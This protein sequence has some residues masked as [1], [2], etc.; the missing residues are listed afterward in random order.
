[1]ATY[2]ITAPD[3]STV[4]LSAK[5]PEQA[6]DIARKSWQSLPRLVARAGG[7]RILQS[8]D[9]A[10]SFTDGTYSTTN[11]ELVA[12]IEAGESPG[13]VAISSQ[14]QATIAQHPVAAI[15]NEYVRG[16]LGVGSRADEAA[17]AMFGPGATQGMRALSGAMERERPGTSAL[18]GIAGAATSVAGLLGALPA[19]ATQA[20]LGQMGTGATRMLPQMARAVLTGTPLAAMEG[21]IY[22]SGEGTTSEERAANAVSGA[23]F[24]AGAGVIGGVAG[25]VVGRG[26]ENMTNYLRNSAPK[27]IAEVL[28]ISAE[29]ARVIKATFEQGGDF[30]A[31]QANLQRAGSEGMLVDAG[32]AAQALADATAASG[33]AASAAVKQ[34]IED[35]ASRVAGAFESQLDATLGP[36]PLGPR[37]KIEE[38]ATRTKPERDAAYGAALS[39]PVDYSTGAPGEAILQ[40]LARIAPEDKAAA[41]KSAN[42]AMLADGIPS[43]ALIKTDGTTEPLYNAT[44]LHYLSRALGSMA[45]SAKGDFGKITDETRIFGDL[46]R[47]LT[48]AMDKAIPGYREAT[49][50]GGDKI[51]EERAFKLGRDLLSTDTEIEDVMLELGAN[52]SKAALE[53][54]RSG[55]RSAIGKALGDVRAIPTDPNIDARQA[56]KALSMFS[57]PNAKAKVRALLGKD[58]DAILAQIDKVSQTMTVRSALATNSK[59]ASRL[60]TQKSVDEIIAPG[61]LGNALAGE[62]INTSKALIQAVTGQTKAFTEKRKQQ[63][64]SDIAT[65][66]TQKRGKEAAQALRYI[67]SAIKG[68]TL[69]EAQNNF[70]AK[71]LA[72]ALY[73]TTLGATRA[74]DDNRTGAQ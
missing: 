16:A 42:R 52:P 43:Q 58:A 47:G 15:G 38:I 22:G 46:R 23:Q 57:S 2:E 49:A 51:A 4:V 3:G 27:V 14:D 70:V 45:E 67:E 62:P 74:V 29:A 54:A 71:Q 39:Q 31:A 69:T 21:A 50:I 59:T 48:G 24:G 5:D 32:E 64:Y 6:R 68:Q 61:M 63:I 56:L 17:G 10:K 65:A 35:R 55:M 26:A 44:Q 9:G 60:A 19:K 30:A 36:A 53:A 7:G 20:L 73:G 33:G 37:T 66:L 8:P 11:P 41:W 18:A 12:R 28:G 34:P 13:D 40:Q 1:M 25:P 72:G